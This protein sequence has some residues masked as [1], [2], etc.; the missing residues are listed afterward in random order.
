MR[1]PVELISR[2]ESGGQGK[3]SLWGI[4]YSLFARHTQ[5]HIEQKT[6]Q[7]KIII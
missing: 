2:N 6:R 4:Y 1:W 3:L 5:S 7:Q